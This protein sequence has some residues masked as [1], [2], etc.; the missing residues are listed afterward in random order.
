M[1]NIHSDFKML[2]L[3]LVKA[4]EFISTKVIKCADGRTAEIMIKKEKQ[5][6]S[7]KAHTVRRNQSWLCKSVPQELLSPV[8]VCLGKQPGRSLLLHREPT[9]SYRRL[10][11]FRTASCSEPRHPVSEQH[12]SFKKPSKSFRAGVTFAN[13]TIQDIRFMYL[14]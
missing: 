5:C 1:G 6:K 11:C 13:A 9:C 4:D 8:E 10:G 14:F 7:P 3:I 2:R 12:F